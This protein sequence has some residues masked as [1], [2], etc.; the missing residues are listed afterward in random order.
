MVFHILALLQQGVM[1]F[2]HGLT[3]LRAQVKVLS[4]GFSDS[5]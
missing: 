3:V 4:L 1:I 5:M 2:E